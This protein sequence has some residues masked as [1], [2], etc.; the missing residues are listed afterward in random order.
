LYLTLMRVLSISIK[1]TSQMRDNRS[2]DLWELRVSN[3]P[4][5]PGYQF[6]LHGAR[7][8]DGVLESKR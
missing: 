4:E 6:V 2:L 8:I 3:L 1:M 7:A 5:R